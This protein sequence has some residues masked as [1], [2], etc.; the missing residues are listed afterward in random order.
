MSLAVKRI[1][2]IHHTHTDLGFTDY[3]AIAREMHRRYLD[4]ALDATVAT[5]DLPPPS[6]F[7]WTAE[8]TIPVADWWQD[9][10]AAQRKQML[11]T[12]QRGQIEITAMPF[13]QTP[14]LDASQWQLLTRW[15]PDSLRAKV[16]PL[17]AMQNDVNG[18]P[19][20]GAMAMMDVGVKFLVMGIN[21]DPSWSLV[22]VP[23]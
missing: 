12:I 19:R 13:N 15:L 22:S 16:R 6:R 5:K 9:A 7:Y 1:N 10:P 11:E 4:I 23:G 20:A 2:I 17:T 14:T 21:A 3:H 8:A 18:F